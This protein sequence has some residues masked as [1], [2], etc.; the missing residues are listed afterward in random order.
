VTTSIPGHEDSEEPD[1]LIEDL[2]SIKDLLD[3]EQLEELS[4]KDDIDVPLLDDPLEDVVT[5]DE[6]LS[7]NTFQTL[8]GDTWQDSVEELFDEAR[9]KIEAH[10]TQWLPEHTD[11]LA[12][13]LKVRIDASVRAW[14]AETLEAN[15]GRLRERI[16]SELS[17]EIL[18]HMRDKLSAPTTSKDQESDHG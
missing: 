10:S 3:E 4:G 2:K 13:A 12:E 15:I 8:L 18:N 16:V 1:E 14:L 11:E 7:D 17:T 6:G 9:R 5:V